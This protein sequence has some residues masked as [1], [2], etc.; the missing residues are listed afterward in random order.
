MCMCMLHVYVHTACVCKGRHL[1][2]PEKWD[3]LELESQV[4][5]SCLTVDA[6]NQTPVISKNI[7]YS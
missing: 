4:V 1:Q 2:R 5:V 7:T 6:G 3:A